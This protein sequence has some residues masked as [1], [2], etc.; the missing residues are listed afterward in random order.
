M[1]KRIAGK[2]ELKSNGFELSCKGDFSCNLGADK[3]EGMVDSR[4]VIGYSAKPQVPFIEG[5][6][7]DFDDFSV[8][9]FLNTTGATIT[10]KAGNGKTFMLED[11]W[12]AGEGDIS[13][14]K[15]EVQC[16]FEGMDAEEMG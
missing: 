3:R 6:I 11:A 16:R 2:F 7:S 9:D 13:L 14:E 8:T 15:G 12:Y 1:S 10:I 5:S 4:K